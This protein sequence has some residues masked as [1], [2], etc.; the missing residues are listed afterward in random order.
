MVDA[1][2]VPTRFTSTRGTAN[3]VEQE[4]TEITKKRIRR[5]N[6]V[7]RDLS[8]L[9]SFPLQLLTDLQRP[10]QNSEIG[11]TLIPQFQVQGGKLRKEFIR[12]HL[13]IVEIRI[14]RFDAAPGLGRLRFIPLITEQHSDQEPGAVCVALVLREFA[15]GFEGVPAGL[16]GRSGA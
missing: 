7:G 2:P 16:V 1:K 8:P 13:E 6:S 12:G 10:V 14:Q 3:K 11:S 15:G 4:S 9:P 5:G